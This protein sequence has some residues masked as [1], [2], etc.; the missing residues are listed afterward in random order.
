MGYG[1]VTVGS[2]SAALIVSANT[3]RL[4]LIIVNIGSS[5]IYIGDD[6]SVSSATGLGIDAYQSYAEASGGQRMFLGDIYGI[7][8]DHINDVRYWERNRA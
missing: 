4:S 5:F 8:E 1:K 6:P 2:G 3:L 7:A